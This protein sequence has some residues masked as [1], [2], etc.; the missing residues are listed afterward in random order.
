MKISPRSLAIFAA[1]SLLTMGAWLA[2]WPESPS[3]PASPPPSQ[4]IPAEK[5]NRDS[6]AVLIGRLK[7]SGS[8]RERLALV[9][10]LSR[11]PVPEIPELLS[12][13]PLEE[14][15]QLTLAARTLLIRWASADGKAAIDW[16][17]A[18]LKEQSAWRDAFLQVCE[19]WAWSDPS[20][21]ER[22]VVDY[23]EHSTTK[24][25]TLEEVRASET[26]I[27]N[28]GNITR[29]AKSLLRE[30]PRAAYVVFLKRGGFSTGDDFMWDSLD[31]PL[32]IEKALTAFGDLEPMKATHNSMTFRLGPM[33][34]AESLMATWMKIDPEGF[35]KSRYPAYLH[36]RFKEAR[37]A[38]ALVQE[39]I[40]EQSAEAAN[41]RIEA[42]KPEFRLGLVRDIGMR[43][44]EKD[45]LAC[46]A[47][48]ENLPPEQRE[49]AAFG[50]VITGTP[51]ELTSTLD[52][53][54]RFAGGQGQQCF[55]TAY[56]T[57]SRAHPGERPDMTAWTEQR[58]RAWDDLEALRELTAP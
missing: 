36:P 4:A 49:Q 58:R 10:E 31:D 38:T 18:N 16:S 56:D 41:L 29:I 47:W 21:L 22:W 27:L 43:W 1:A 14:N 5:W 51:A 50:T 2:F 40:A 11:V 52:W 46:R 44:G 54:E 35:S 45:P 8:E 30:D 48:A 3:L 24:D 6:L 20:S 9:A 15:Y 17:W 19:A 33:S 39:V 37:Q 12:T 7:A 53:L 55:V 23:F 26:P 28:S 34:Y 32:Q 25:P 57:W 42:T 13:I